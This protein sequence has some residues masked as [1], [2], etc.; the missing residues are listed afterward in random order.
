M[1]NK[2]FRLFVSSTFN[3]FLQERAILNECIFPEINAYCQQRGYNFQ[4]IDL[5]WG[6]TNESAIN[7]KTVEICLDEVKRCRTLSPKPNF[8]LMVGERY[9]WI[10]LPTGI[11]PNEFEQI[12]GA[13]EK[14]EL[15]I[16]S[17]W[18]ELDENKIG[19]EYYLKARTGKYIDYNEWIVEETAIHNALI[20]CSA[21]IANISDKTKKILSSSATEREI[22]EGLLSNAGICDNTIAVFR[23]GYTNKDSDLSKINDLRA[24]IIKRMS[25]DR[26]DDNVLSLSWN[27]QYAEQFKKRISAVL[28][29]NIEKEITRIEQV[30]EK[31]DRRDT[32]LRQCLSLDIVINRQSYLDKIVDYVKS[33]DNRPMFLIG[34]S[35]S[36]KTTLL[37]EYIEQNSDPDVFFAFYGLDEFSYLYI[38]CLKSISNSICEKYQTENIL[39]ITEFNLTE[40]M[41]DLIGLIPK[42]KNAVVIIDGLDMFQDIGDIHE[43]LIPDKLPSNVKIVISCATGKI[44]DRFL[45]NGVVLSLNKFTGEESI[46]YFRS[47]LKQKNRVIVPEAQNGVITKAIKD[48]ATPLQIKIVSDI[49]ATWRSSESVNGLPVSADDMALQYMESMF[50]KLGHNRALVLSALSL[51]AASPY[52]VT[53][54]ELQLLLLRFPDVESFFVTEDR[55]HHNMSRLPFVIW[56]RLFYDLKGCLTLVKDSGYIVVKFAHNIFQR[57]FEERY[58]ECVEFAWQILVDY[59]TLQDN[60]LAGSQ[61][62]N[63]RKTLVLIYLLK[64]MNKIQE[65]SDLLTDLSFVDA[66]VKTGNIDSLIR[67]YNYLINR[68]ENVQS[69]KTE[70][71][72]IYLCLRDHHE[73]LSCY[74]DEFNSCAAENG[75]LDIKTVFTLQKDQEATVKN[76]SLVFPYSP[77]SKT[78]WNME[79]GKYAVFYKSYVYICDA[80]TGLELCRVF[81]PPMRVGSRNNILRVLWVNNFTI[82]AAVYESDIFFFDI[83]DETPNV[84][85]IIETEYE[86]EDD[87]KII[88]QYGLFLFKHK[89]QV[90]VYELKEGQKIKKVYSVDVPHN[91]TQVDVAEDEIYFKNKLNSISVCSVESGKLIRKINLNNKISFSSGSEQMAGS[92][93]HKVED[94]IWLEQTVTSFFPTSYIYDLDRNSKMN[95][96]LPISGYGGGWLVGHKKVLFYEDNIILLVSLEDYSL[97]YCKGDNIKNIAWVQKDCEISVIS[98]E[99]L[100]R[101][102]INEFQEFPDGPT[103][104]LMQR[105]SRFSLTELFETISVSSQIIRPLIGSGWKREIWDYDK[106]FSSSV[107]DMEKDLRKNIVGTIVEASKQGTKAIVFEE[108]NTIAIYDKENNLISAIKN[109]KLG[110]GN[111]LLRLEFI[112]DCDCL[113]VWCNYYLKVFD[114]FHGKVLF[115]LNLKKRPL[116][117]LRIDERTNTVLLTFYN[118][119]EVAMDI[120][121]HPWFVKHE[122]Y[123][124]PI[125]KNEDLYCGPYYS[126]DAESGKTLKH[127]LDLSRIE[128]NFEKVYYTNTARMFSDTF[129]YR[130]ENYQLLYKDGFYKLVS[131]EATFDNNL[132]YFSKSELVEQA[133]DESR[134][135]GFLRRKNDLFSKLYEFDGGFLVLVARSLN[136][137]VAF[138]IKSMKVLAAYKINGNIIGC[139]R[140]GN[141]ITVI[142]DRSP[143]QMRFTVSL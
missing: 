131:D 121:R 73:M 129:V 105:K 66:V 89:K 87:I 103:H 80:A 43:S 85:D 49:C 79:S 46:E 29:T 120:K 94:K 26:C 137:L 130:S 139:T 109:L 16:I 71:S 3:D 19:G 33:N 35:G 77:N 6:I 31:I 136:S 1:I 2:T 28:K 61:F 67:D 39:D 83:S 92:A 65:M 53:E 108:K 138:D 48:G 93:L 5:R 142:L 116:L 104:V 123:K 14:T 8:L 101:I 68:V 113:L 44:A 96:V 72:R 111:S 11:S 140:D 30:K 114:V 40:S 51:I 141:D 17:K 41:Y 125:C 37:A 58:S 82:A 126:Y 9:G 127:M 81:I 27:E 50:K 62:P 47:F 32:V 143:Y 15:E 102:Q 52:G 110:V 64:R 78:E 124:I 134:L 54:E 74:M 12:I 86:T 119:Q 76:S 34:D 133:M 106:I 117:N 22:V 25:G 56:S 42:D 21:R 55:Y 132:K 57:V 70:L 18:Y 23:N 7:Q 128:N 69:E 115:S 88:S 75:L 60:T 63:T 98:D 90:R 59:Y 45:G 4:L 112:G 84:I 13:A 122:I 20:A 91:G 118:K 36:G 38:D 100:T 95:L 135:Y 10:P 97:K 107:P 24:R 99:G